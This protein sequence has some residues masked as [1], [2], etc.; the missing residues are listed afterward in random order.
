MATI[1]NLYT[2]D[3]STVDRSFTFPYLDSADI[4]VSLD[5]VITTAY[6]L[7]NATTIRFNTAPA[8]GV[9][10][11][12]YRDTSDEALKA[13][14][15]PGSAIRAEDLN[16]NALQNLYVTQEANEKL[17][18]A[19]T[20]GDETI[21][22][23]EAWHTSDDTR[24]AST[25]AIEN[26]IAAQIDTAITGDVLV[27]TDISK[28]TSGGQVTLS[29][30]VAGA[31]TTI[32]NSNANVLQDITVTAQG[33]VTNVSSV[34][35]DTRYYT[36]TEIAGGAL[37][38][39][40]YTKTEL[41]AGQLNNV[42][43][44][45]TELNAGQ[46][47][48]RYFTETECNTNFQPKDAELTEL[49][50]MGTDTAAALADL[51]Q[52]EV[53]ILDGAT[54]STTELNKLDGATLSTTEI[55]ILDGATV[56]TSEL[57][58]LDG[59]TASTANLN[60]VS[61]KT[62]RASGDGTL[63]TTSD[64]EIPSSKVIAAHI[65]SSVGAVGGFTVVANDASFPA[66]ASQP[67]NGVVVSI[68]DAAG[69]VING[70]GVSTTGRTTDGTPATVTI[71]SFPSSLNG[72]T[73]A[74]GVGLQ[75][76]STGSS[77]TY[78]Y[79]KLLAA[80]TDVKSLSDDINDFNARYRVASSAPGSNNDDGDLWFDTT[81][82]KM[83]VYNATGSSWDVVASVG[84][85][86]INTI[87]S[88][89]GTGGGSATFNGS[90]Y[91]F[92]L[93]DPPTSAQ[94]LLVS[95]NGVI[96]KPNTGTSQ[97]SEGFAIS[98]SDIIFSAAPASGADYFITTQGA[99]V[100]VGTP[101]DNTVTSAKIV[102]GTIVNG[103][104][105]SSAAIVGSKLADDSITEVKL[106]IHNAPS[107]TDKYLK[108]TSNGME[109]VTVD[110]VTSD[111]QN[112][113]VIGLNAGD[114]FDGTNAERNVLIGTEAGT[115]ITTGDRNIGIGLGALDETTTGSNNIAVGDSALYSN[116]TANN[117][118]AVGSNALLDN[119]A[120]NNTAV[121]MNCLQ[122]N[123]TAENNTGVGSGCMDA[124]TTGANNTAVGANALDANTTG[125]QNTAIGKGA[126]SAAQTAA[127]NTAVG[128]D[129]LLASTTGASNTAVGRL[130]ADAVTTGSHNVAIGDLTFRNNTTGSYNTAIGVSSLAGGSTTSYNTAVGYFA[131]NQNSTGTGNVAVGSE[132]LDGNS[133]GSNLVGV[134]Y[135]SLTGN[136]TGSSNVGVGKSALGTNSTGSN[137]VAVGHN[138]LVLST[139][140][141]SNTAVGHQ[142][143]FTN[144]TGT[145]NTAV[146]A[147]ALDA[148]QTANNNTAMGYNAA[149]ATTTGTLNTAVG[150][151]ALATNSTGGYNTAIGQNALNSSTTA[152][153]N[154][155]VGQGCLSTNTTGADNSAVGY[156]A[157]ASA[158]TDSYNTAM[159]RQALANLQGSSGL[160]TAIGHNAG[161]TMTTGTS[162][163]AVGA[164]ALD[165]C[166]TSPSNT[167]VGKNA[168]GSITTGNGENVCIGNN[169][170]AAM[171]TGQQNVFIGDNA[172]GGGAVTGA[173]N[174]CV[175]DNAGYAL[176]TPSFNSAF[177]STTLDTCTTGSNNT[178]LGYA[179][180]NDV[181]T[182]TDNIGIGY[183]T[184][185]Y[186]VPLT[187]G[188]HNIL[189]GTD[190][191]TSA[192]GGDHQIVI[193]TYQKQA[194][195]NS[196]AFISANG[197]ACYQGD[198]SSSWSTTSDR[199]IKKNI[200]DNEV[201]LDKI[202]QITVRNFEY[203]TET[204]IATDNP[205][206]TD[207]V[208]SA[209]V[210]KEGIQLGVIA[211]EIE[212]ILPDVVKTE[213]T[214]VKSVDP[215]NLTWYLV[216]AIKELSAKVTALEGN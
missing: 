30:N 143:L 167:C 116:T 215:S 50:T 119:T 198:N 188:G 186:S 121:G 27:G 162:N 101:S 107:G 108:Y 134:G 10:I 115:A 38:N 164:N 146:G 94:Q 125:N 85:F 81:A 23:T 39:N 182:G 201:G 71:N 47:D 203:K 176:T 26:R 200:V 106:D 3:N 96:Q 54:L 102:D 100:S 35:L 74:S 57:N 153:H 59:V 170:G 61:G 150:S 142:T 95:V 4:K 42:Y 12:I 173:S 8:T 172:S 120:A 163:T 137:N 165:E 70:S 194:K 124:N 128:N 145:Q 152:S 69:V 129:A 196:T 204:E 37:N 214:G 67:A 99:S 103:D 174:T 156:N 18:T 9:A 98:G 149:T 72:E 212:T 175:G 28:A 181:T 177:G 13:T 141:S 25:K 1:E 56:N 207:V 135:N 41:N 22:S 112:N 154:T 111:A 11:R 51:N 147:F 6:A 93:S 20:T 24:I 75:V 29:H 32:N 169:C 122:N 183:R 109:W 155:A 40:Y 148:S 31:D 60:I 209:A 62:F 171:T 138:A 191:Y 14:F 113:V 43:Y 65:A 193:G 151:E 133:T 168:G 184:G 123:T 63:T 213:S 202:N 79:H 161:F 208:K 166:T 87:S 178:A 91:R 36:K 126:L 49:A 140:S 17:G 189:I 77:N 104:I 157:L 92:T 46:L 117:N 68:N 131:L 80:E 82:N 136:T 97:P 45:E 53:Q 78:T 83:K 132:S 211:Q 84:D 195:G 105:S 76:V 159:G 205:E 158:T 185:G 130:A 127:N 206:L 33:H 48:N 64:T 7:H 21:I 139:T 5:G 2:G 110:T 210:K 86:Y 52:G 144:T 15:Y 190:A 160:N 118:V 16:E 34:D 216:N 187:T 58:K 88:S 44:T 73:L 19:W 179:A 180:L 66:T 55:N 199:R 89:S 197:G 114:A 90:A 192:A